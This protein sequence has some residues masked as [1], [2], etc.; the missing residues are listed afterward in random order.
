MGKKGGKSKG[1]I[2]QGKHSNVD[3]KIVNAMRSEYLQSSER[4]ANQLR[5]LKQGKDVVMTIANPNKEQTHKRFIKV[6]VSG[7]EYVAR[8]K[9]WNR[10]AKKADGE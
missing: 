4:L 8:L 9:D 2:S 1:F 7:R 5:A 10:S 6:K 3:R